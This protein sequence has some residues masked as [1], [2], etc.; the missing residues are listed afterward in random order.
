M[1]S[2]QK[3]LQIEDMEKGNEAV[4]LFLRHAHSPAHLLRCFP[5]ATPPGRLSVLMQC[6]AFVSELAV[7]KKKKKKCLHVSRLTLDWINTFVWT[8]TSFFHCC[9]LMLL[10]SCHFHFSSVISVLYCLPLSVRFFSLAACVGMKAGLSVVLPINLCAA[11]LQCVCAACPSLPSKNLL[12]LPPWFQELPFHLSTHYPILSLSF[13]YRWQQWAPFPYIQINTSPSADVFNTMP[14][15]SPWLFFF[16]SYLAPV[17][18]EGVAS[19]LSPFLSPSS[20]L[21][22]FCQTVTI[23]PTTSILDPNDQKQKKKYRLIRPHDRCIRPCHLAYFLFFVFISLS[24]FARGML[25]LQPLK[26]WLRMRIYLFVPLRSL[27]RTMAPLHW[28]LRQQF[29]W[30]ERWRLALYI[31]VHKGSNMS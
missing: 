26:L 1:Q 13:S 15:V 8:L 5:L 29:R 24:I 9:L 4:W 16:S 22:S 19:S 3:R 2:M 20:L 11:F 14:S 17:L 30:S 21:L 10:L 23:S 31:D 28:V 18:A 25:I 6:V 27:S 12:I 7:C